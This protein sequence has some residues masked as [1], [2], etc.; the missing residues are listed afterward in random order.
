MI[1]KEWSGQFTNDI[2]LKAGQ[3]AEKQMAFYLKREFG[4]DKNIFVFN[5]I[6]IIHEGEV[7]Q[8]DHLILHPYGFILI[9]SKSITGSV[10]INKH[11]EWIRYYNGK[12]SGMRSP[13]IQLEMQKDILISFL[14][15]NPE[16]FLGKLLGLVQKGVARRSYDCITAISDQAI[17]ERKQE[18]KDVYK[19]DAVTTALRKKIKQY[20][21]ELITGDS[22]WFSKNDLQN[23]TNFLLKSDTSKTSATLKKQ[24]TLENILKEPKK[25]HSSTKAKYKKPPFSCPKCKIP[26]NIRYSHNHY[27]YCQ[28]C[29]SCEPLTP[30]CPKCSSSAKLR[31]IERITTYNCTKNSEH[32]GIFYKNEKLWLKDKNKLASETK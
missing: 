16:E 9:E 12:P 10:E 7:A 25:T 27:L 4:K 18:I 2:R 29:R 23:I 26:F 30:I 13:P 32:H 1:V 31:L 20:K 11:G 15:E 28:N 19:A 21:R 8:I 17:I 14:D 5:N 22:V 24:N 6:R 3:E